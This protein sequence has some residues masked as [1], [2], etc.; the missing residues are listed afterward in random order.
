MID[1]R[2][3][4]NYSENFTSRGVDKI[5]THFSRSAT[6]I[7]TFDR[8]FTFSMYD[9]YDAKDPSWSPAAKQQRRNLTAWVDQKGILSSAMGKVTVKRSLDIHTDYDLVDTSITC[10]LATGTGK[11]KSLIL[12]FYDHEYSQFGSTEKLSHFISVFYKC[13]L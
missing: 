11:Q 10:V 3:D 12:E 4:I 5:R 6:L 9:F 13:F 7:G 2:L 8:V 1:C